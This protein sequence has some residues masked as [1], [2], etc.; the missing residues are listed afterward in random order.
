MESAA[1]VAQAHAPYDVERVR[2]DFPILGRRV[3][4]RPLVYLDNA[5]SAQKP[6][7]VIEAE[8]SV[9][10][11]E[12]ANI[13]RGPHYLSERTTARFE[14]AR[15]KVCA[16]LNANHHH[17]IIF[18]RNATEAINL[19]AASYGRA[20]LEAGDEIVLSELEHHA[21]IVPWQM[22]R[23]EKGVVLKVAPITDAGEFRLEEFTRLLGPKTKLVAISHMSNALGTILP[24]QEIV[25][26]AHA[27]GAKALIDGAQAVTHLG[28]DMQELDCDFYVFSGHKLYGPSGIGVLYGRDELLDAMPPYQGGG[29]MIRRVTWEETLWAPLPNKFEAGTPAIAQAIGLGAAI[30]YL[31]ALGME[32][33]AAHEADLLAYA[34]KAVSAIPGLSIF[35]TA[36]IKA[37]VLSFTLENAHPHDIGT[38]L[39]RSGVAI[40]AGHH[41]AQPLMD[42]MGV[43]ATARASFALY[44]TRA[45]ID[46]LVEALGRV[47]EIFS[48]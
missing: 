44:N 33:I 14:E 35:G 20:F 4:D 42:R 9:Y 23:E 41:C 16:F 15:N 45:E 47:Q 26:M 13:H 17:E 12:Y 37:S 36:P 34:T 11:E 39:D 27:C 43:T 8:L 31:D 21:N 28:V 19:V 48:K 25:R 18:T 5:A 32:R 29:D 3:Y 10:R 7:Q 6:S 46:A 38:I 40:R 24:V 22:L 1:Q 2:A 30:D